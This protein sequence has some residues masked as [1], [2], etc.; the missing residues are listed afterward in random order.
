MPDPTF[1]KRS[2]DLDGAPLVVRFQSPRR[3]PEGDFECRWTIGWP[4][5][6][7]SHQACGVDGIQ[8]LT[9]AM[10]AVHD[11]LLESEAY[12]AGRL[13]LWGQSDL[14]LPPSWTTGPLYQLPPPPG[15][16]WPGQ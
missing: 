2:F 4:E 13:S 5:G 10:Q 15:G 11:R 16:K 3:A 9:L 8:A 7:T 12:K 6:E 14:D 1:V